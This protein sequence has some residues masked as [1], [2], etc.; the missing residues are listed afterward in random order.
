MTSKAEKSSTNDNLCNALAGDR[1]WMMNIQTQTRSTRLQSLAHDEKKEKK[2]QMYPK[3]QRH[4]EGKNEQ[5][6]NPME[7]TKAK[8]LP[9]TGYAMSRPILVALSMAPLPPRLVQ[10]ACIDSDCWWRRLSDSG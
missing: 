5:E 1:E 7:K 2:N 6:A 9:V 8:R 10:V 4:L 3:Y